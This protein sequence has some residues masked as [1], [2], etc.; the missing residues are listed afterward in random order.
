MVT[1]QHTAKGEEDKGRGEENV[2]LLINYDNTAT[3]K[4]QKILS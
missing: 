3:K 1:E 2:E 4:K